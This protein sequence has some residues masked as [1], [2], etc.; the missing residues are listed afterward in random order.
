MILSATPKL[1]FAAM[2]SSLKRIFL[3][4]DLNEKSESS[5]VKEEPAFATSY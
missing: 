2:K 5:N 3:N 4:N 1:E